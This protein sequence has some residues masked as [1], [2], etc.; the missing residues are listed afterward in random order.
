[1]AIHVKGA[2]IRFSSSLPAALTFLFAHLFAS[3]C[4]RPGS[5]T[6]MGTRKSKDPFKESVLGHSPYFE[7]EFLSFLLLCS[8][9]QTRQSTSCQ[10]ILLSSSLRAVGAMGLQMCATTS[11]FYVGT[12]D[13]NTGC[14]LYLASAFTN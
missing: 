1:M 10:A 7:A 9:H 4:T 12:G 14:Q 13:P 3:V 11:R 8:L 6:L 2:T 5:H